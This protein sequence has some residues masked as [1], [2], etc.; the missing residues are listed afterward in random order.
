MMMNEK[1]QCGD[2]VF[3][4]NSG[5]DQS[6]PSLGKCRRYPPQ[7]VVIQE[8]GNV[9]VMDHGIIKQTGQQQLIQKIRGEYP[10][11]KFNDMGCGEFISEDDYNAD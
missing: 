3:W 1:Q 2:C 5:P 6:N 7:M 10:V 8:I 11:L 9:T 4:D